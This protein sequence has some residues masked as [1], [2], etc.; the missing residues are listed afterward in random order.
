MTPNNILICPLSRV[1][2]DPHQRSFFSQEM[3]IN[4]GTTIGQHSGSE[5]L[6]SSVLNDVLVK[7]PTSEIRDLLEG[8]AKETA[9]AREGN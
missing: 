6:W 5:K 2:L 3:G 9:G 7:P 4:A 1:S 8:E